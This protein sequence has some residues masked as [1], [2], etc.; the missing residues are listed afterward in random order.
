MH[1]LEQRVQGPCN[2]AVCSHEVPSCELGVRGDRAGPTGHRPHVV[3]NVP[4]LRVGSSWDER[5]ECA[6]TGTVGCMTEESLRAALRGRVLAYRPE[7]DGLRA[8]SL[9]L[10]ITAHL[11]PSSF[12]FG[13]LGVDVFFVLSG[14][15]I[16]ELLLRSH[17]VSLRAF[18][19]RRF[20]RL[21][22]AL[23]VVVTV[24]VAVSFTGIW[25]F[26]WWV[27]LV[28][29]GYAMNLVGF[30]TSD[31]VADP[32]TPTWSLAAEEQ[33]YLV[34]PVVLG[35]LTRRIGRRR[36][37]H[38]LMAGVFV[39][40]VAQFLLW[41]FVSETTLRHGPFFRPVGLLLGSAVALYGPPSGRAVRLARSWLIVPAVAAL[42]ALGARGSNGMFISLATAAV[43]VAFTA[44]D[45]VT[46]RVVRALSWAPLTA[47]GRRSY[48]LYLWNLPSMMF[49]AHFLGSGAAGVVVGVVATF[50]IGFLSFRL[51]EIPMLRRFAPEKPK[52]ASSPA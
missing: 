47:I 51:V 24:V 40:F 25:S 34:W 22:P 17:D 50:V 11:G 6:S 9:L 7:L 48:S 26:P 49:A 38:M 42:V 44:P 20:A 30:F 31:T 41:D 14:F 4:Q 19:R 33:Y 32:L 39:T 15:L 1:A 35:L 37:A 46:A 2:R 5:D 3:R 28:A 13:F 21:L 23:V 10:V 27:P 52:P 43:L 8:L 45:P 18:Y 12:R 36:L 29:V 16:T